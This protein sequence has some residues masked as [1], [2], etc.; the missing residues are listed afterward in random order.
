MKEEERPG[1]WRDGAPPSERVI[2][3]ARLWPEIRS[4][5]ASVQVAK[6]KPIG[7]E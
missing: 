5:K 1:S 2:T 6:V 3:V 7:R 4:A